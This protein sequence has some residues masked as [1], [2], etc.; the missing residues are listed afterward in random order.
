MLS[1]LPA[2]L[3][4]A[5]PPTFLPTPTLTPSPTDH[6]S[7]TEYARSPNK[8]KAEDDGRP[9][10]IGLG[11]GLSVSAKKARTGD[12][13]PSKLL[14]LR[15]PELH[16]SS[17]SSSVQRLSERGI[18]PADRS[19]PLVS[20]KKELGKSGLR[21]EITE[22]LGSWTKEDFVTAGKS[23]VHLEPYLESLC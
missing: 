18:T 9:A 15:S 22:G 20:A 23:F 19:S 1:S 13:P 11:L 7:F 8:R 12:S 14:P 16:R 6:K 17:S 5:L 10:S 4:E 2:P 21:S 3:P